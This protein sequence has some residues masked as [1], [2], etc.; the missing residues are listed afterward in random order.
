MGD[1]KALALDEVR[2]R[3]KE[4]A[5]KERTTFSLAGI[6]ALLEAL[7]AQPQGE[8]REALDGLRAIRPK[9]AVVLLEN[10]TTS[11]R[12]QIVNEAVDAIDAALAGRSK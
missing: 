2:R 1:E 10:F 7:D 8:L 5:D 9:L 6:R 4:H 3:V 11:Q 12:H